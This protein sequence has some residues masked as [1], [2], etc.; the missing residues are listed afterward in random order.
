[1]V[2]VGIIS[3]VAGVL[4][5]TVTAQTA[6]KKSI[7]CHI[8]GQ[9]VDNP[10]CR[11]MLLLVEGTDL[12]TGRCDTIVVDKAGHFTFDLVTMENNVY[13]IFPEN[14]YN[15]G[16]WRSIEFFAENCTVNIKL[17]GLDSGL[18][19]EMTSDG[20][21]N[22]EMLRVRNE[23]TERFYKEP[24]REMRMLRKSGKA[25][26]P[27]AQELRKKM[28]Q[29]R[30]DSERKALAEE[31]ELL[32]KAGKVM[33]PEYAA[34]YEKYKQASHKAME[35][36]LGYAAEKPTLLGLY[37]LHEMANGSGQDD[38]K[39]AGR[40]ETIFDSL[41]ADRYRGNDLSRKMRSWI[42]SR[43]IR[44]GGRFIDF[45][46]PDLDGCNHTLSA[47]IS[48]RIALIDLWASWCGSCRR[49][50]ESMI[51]VYEEFRDRGFTVVG[52]ANERNAENMRRAIAQDG[53]KWLNLLTLNDRELIWERYGCPGAGGMIVLV[54]RDGTI[55]AINPTVD[56]V[57][58]ILNKKLAK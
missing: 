15:A 37:K 41:Y 29:A 27:E 52:V 43:N 2:M 6:G 7:C 23:V 35:Y 10:E 25:Y 26:T 57:R 42:A 36:K 53:Y 13:T 24:G 1:M 5:Q 30:T 54:D 3:T 58:E 16:A 31:A 46:L 20:P 34:A 12:R 47:E 19:L 56:E 38:E 22:N 51:P 55:L 40:V 4:P 14:E 28:E 50:S 21:L 48:G 32:E 11:R 8:K 33:T 49:R 44:P 45:T 9:V 17:Y 39:W 18:P